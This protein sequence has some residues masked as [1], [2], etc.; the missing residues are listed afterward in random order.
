MSRTSGTAWRTKRTCRNKY[1]L[2]SPEPNNKAL[3][4]NNRAAGL[5]SCLFLSERFP[6]PFSQPATDKPHQHTAEN[7]GGE[8]D[9]KAMK[10]PSTRVA[11]AS[12]FF[13]ASQ[14]A[15]TAVKEAAVCPEGNE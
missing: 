7:I 6:Q 3:R 15:A 4:L 13:P 9:A 2:F 12:R 10:T 5:F 11:P 14:R 8:V 1:G